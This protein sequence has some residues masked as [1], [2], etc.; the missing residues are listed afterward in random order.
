MSDVQSM[1]QGVLQEAGYRTWLVAI[2]KRSALCFEDD[3]VMGFACVFNDA[4][5]LLN[6]WREIEMTF[7]RLH[8]D[9]IRSAGEKAWNIYSVFLASGAASNHTQGREIRLIEE[10]LERTRKIAATS[11]THT[12]ALVAAVLPLL[13]LQIQPVLDR[14]DVTERFRRRLLTIA[15]SA[16]E[17]VLNESVSPRDVARRLSEAK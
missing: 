6:D 9:R 8:G 15:P 16:A 17:V 14:E 13:P 12:E 5:S 10:D 3:S 11:I 7:L 1:M 4:A 2:S